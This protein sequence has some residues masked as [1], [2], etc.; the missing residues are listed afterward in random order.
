TT[1]SLSDTLSLHDALP[2]FD[3]FGPVPLITSSE[4]DADDRPS[5]AEKEDFVRF[6]ED[7][8]LDV[9]AVLPVEQTEYG[10]VTKGAA[11]AFLTKFYLNNKKWDKVVE[12][13]DDL[14][15]LGVYG[16]FDG[17]TR[18][19]LFLIENE[20]NKEFIYVRPHI[21]QPG[22]GTNYLPHVAPPNYKYKGAAKTNFAT[23]LKTLSPFL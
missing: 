1:L 7:E 21:A 18:T 10:R 14:I 16:L 9:S 8:L 5:R 17:Q 15:G 6:V 4:V 3:L 20:E 2:I 11:L 12:V 22:L 19:D 13:A 23:Q